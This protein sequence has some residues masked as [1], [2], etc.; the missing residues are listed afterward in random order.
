MCP[1]ASR[2]ITVNTTQHDVMHRSLVIPYNRINHTCKEII[3]SE[4][5][6][7]GDVL[8]M[9][10]LDKIT[11]HFPGMRIIKTVLALLICFLSYSAFKKPASI[12]SIIA[13]IVCLQRGMT[14]TLKS[15]TN[16]VI[17]T[18]VSGIYAYLFIRFSTE[19]LH[20]TP[21]E[22]SYDIL[23]TLFVIPLM[24]GLVKLKKTGSVTIATI[25][26]MVISLPLGPKDPLNYTVV[27]VIDTLIGI[28]AA[29]F[30]EWFPPLNKFGE[31]YTK[32]MKIEVPEQALK[33]LEAKNKQRIF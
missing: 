5:K 20:F 8:S 1:A 16:R 33:D 25:V 9:G 24:Y 26:Y 14:T 2:T 17:G 3:E 13:A 22:L 27:R 21:G 28:M 30:V 18:V 23:V 11:K 4:P 6:I 12:Q 19:V 7:E 32:A 10:K 31:I 15:S 29:V